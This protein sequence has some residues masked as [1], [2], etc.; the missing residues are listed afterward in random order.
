MLKHDPHSSS[1][2]LSV[3]II[4]KKPDKITCNTCGMIGHSSM[5]LGNSECP[6]IQLNHLY[7]LIK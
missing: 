2:L 7:D 3:S 5:G 1:H 4:S 6:S